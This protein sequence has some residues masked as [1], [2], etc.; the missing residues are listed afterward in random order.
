VLWWHGGFFCDALV[1]FSGFDGAFFA[2]SDFFCF[3]GA[4]SG[5]MSLSWLELAAQKMIMVLV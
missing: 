4:D 5:G 1:V 3:F 2:A